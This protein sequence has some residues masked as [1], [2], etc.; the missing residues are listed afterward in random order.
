MV[1][2][3]Q[4]K[5]RRLEEAK[6]TATKAEAARQVAE[7]RVVEVEQERDAALVGSSELCLPRHNLA[8]HSIHEG[9]EF[10]V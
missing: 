8:L 1:A 2:E 4:Q 9:F 6:E 7:E 3:L 5:S 10:H